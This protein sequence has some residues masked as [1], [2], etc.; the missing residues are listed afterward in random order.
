MG[1][2]S[3]CHGTEALQRKIEIN[4]NG[5]ELQMRERKMEAKGLLGL[6]SFFGLRDE[7]NKILS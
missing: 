4:D 1:F 2:M 7:P 6:G 5:R 3:D